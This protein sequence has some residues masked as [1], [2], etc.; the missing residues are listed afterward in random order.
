MSLSLSQTIFLACGVLASL[1]K[2]ATD[3]LAGGRCK[4]YSFV[5]QSISELSAAGAPTRSFVLPLDLVYDFLMVA[6][7]AGVWQ[8]A[9]DNLLM[10]IAAALIAGNAV[11]SFFV[12][13]LL[14]MEI[15]QD[16]SSSA[17]TIHVVLMAIAMFSFLF[18][19]GLAGAAYQDWFRYYSFGT[20][21]AYLLLAIARFAIPSPTS[22]GTPVAMVGAQER[23]MVLGY[24]LWVVVLAIHEAS[25]SSV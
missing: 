21:L 2:A 17:S 18:A 15:H 19:I 7:A 22:G 16:G 9:A 14:P 25:K 12:I 1:L 5:S 4:G 13:S 6:F 23:T 11:I 10:G 20:L 24:L 8:L 3:V